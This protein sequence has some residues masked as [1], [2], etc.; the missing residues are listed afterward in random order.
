MLHFSSLNIYLYYFYFDHILV[1]DESCSLFR[2]ADGGEGVVEELDAAIHSICSI[3][4][5]IVRYFCSLV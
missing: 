4:E 5:P 3:P 1:P 2:V